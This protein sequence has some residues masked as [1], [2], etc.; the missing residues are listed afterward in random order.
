[1][2]PQTTTAGVLSATDLRHRMEQSEAARAADL[3]RQG[4]DEETRQKAAYDEFHQ[5]PTVTDEQLMAQVMQPVQRAAEN[6]AAEVQFYRFPSSVCL[7]RGRMINNS[8]PDWPASLS[9]RPQL[10]YEFWREQLR[11][12]GFGL[13]AQILDYPGG[14]PGD[15]GFFP[16]W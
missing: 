13:K 14:F 7:D 6:C 4:S 16:T 3:A 10:A 12:L 8:A 5:P 9:G 11:P 15:V 2:D 1:M